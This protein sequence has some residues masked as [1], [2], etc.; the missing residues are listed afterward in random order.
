MVFSSTC[1][2]FSHLPLGKEQYKIC[3]YCDLVQILRHVLFLHL[4]KP[5]KYFTFE[6]DTN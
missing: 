4:P 5:E 3:N 2:I 6:Y 1:F